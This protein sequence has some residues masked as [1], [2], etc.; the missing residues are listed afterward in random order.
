MQEVCYCGRVGEVEDREPVTDAYGRETLRCPNDACGHL[1]DLSWVL[2][3]GHVF[4]QVLL[5]RRRSEAPPARE[6]LAP[7]AV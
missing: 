1:D 5:R 6:V 2:D 7:E 3:P 4:R